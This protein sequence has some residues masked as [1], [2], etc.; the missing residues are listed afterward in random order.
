MFTTRTVD[1]AVKQL[2]NALDKLNIISEDKKQEINT[3]SVRINAAQNECT[4]ADRIIG[5]LEELLK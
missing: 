3:L 2:Q 4:R 1:D 5:K